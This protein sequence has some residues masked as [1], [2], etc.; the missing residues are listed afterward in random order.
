MQASVFLLEIFI[1]VAPGVALAYNLNGIG[2]II[3]TRIQFLAT[4]I[5]LGPLVCNDLMTL[6]HHMMQR[7]N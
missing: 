2:L 4:A 1:H 7:N 6:A 3:I 5:N